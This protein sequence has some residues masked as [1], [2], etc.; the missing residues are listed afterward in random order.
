MLYRSEMTYFAI[1]SDFGSDLSTLY[2]S[3][4]IQRFEFVPQCVAWHAIARH[5]D[6]NVT[7]IGRQILLTWCNKTNI[8]I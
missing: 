8:P 2:V 7:H 5:R 3:I 1:K 4:S 6:G